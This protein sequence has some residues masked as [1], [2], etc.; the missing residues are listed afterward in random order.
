MTRRSLQ[1]LTGGVLALALVVMG[2]G[3]PAKTVPPK[4]YAN[5]VCTELN[6]WDAKMQSSQKTLQTKTTGIGT[7]FTKLKPVVVAYLGTAE[8]VLGEATKQLRQAGT[9]DTP[10]GKAA[11]KALTG[12][13]EKA[14][15]AIAG[16][17]HDAAKLPTGSPVK[18]AASFKT[19][20]TKVNHALSGLNDTF[21][22]VSK[23]DPKNKLRKAFAATKA[24]QSSGG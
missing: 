20:T 24:C 21:T 16:L 4:Q 9:P 8:N 19:L 13:F 11:A 6:R 5:S 12:G 15:E 10:Q 3:F 7:D 23:H 14:R 18:A 17:K 1:V 22:N 2:A